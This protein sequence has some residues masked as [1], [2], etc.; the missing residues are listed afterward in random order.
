MGKLKLWV[1]KEDK[2]NKNN[3]HQEYEWVEKYNVDDMP[4]LRCMKPTRA[5][6]SIQ[7]LGTLPSARCCE[8]VTNP[9]VK[10]IFSA[11]RAPYEAHREGC[12][13]YH[14]KEFCSYDMQLRR[15]DSIFK[16][17]DLISYQWHLNC[18]ASF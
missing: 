10:I 14:F 7:P 15:S 8:I 9:T 5:L 11:Y 2:E 16:I 3:Q 6:I 13:A 1:L 18:L 4:N 12:N 17:K